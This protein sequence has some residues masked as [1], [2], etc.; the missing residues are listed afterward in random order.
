[1][2]DGERQSLEKEIDFHKETYISY[3]RTTLKY[4]ILPLIQYVLNPSPFPINRIPK[5]ANWY[6]LLK[7]RLRPSTRSGLRYS[8][9]SLTLS[10]GWR[11]YHQ[12][13]PSAI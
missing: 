2:H 4:S 7:A 12:I 6:M 5:S 10:L 3:V 13:S 11:Y 8:G 1:M 9:E